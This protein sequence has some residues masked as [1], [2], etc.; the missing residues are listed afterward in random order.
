MKSYDLLKPGRLC[1]GV[2]GGHRDWLQRWTPAGQVMVPVIYY[3]FSCTIEK[4]PDNCQRH[5]IERKHGSEW[6][7]NCNNC[8]CDNGAVK[9]T[10][11]LC[12][13]QNCIS[14][15]T[16]RA[17]GCE[18]SGSRCVEMKNVSCL[19][20][21]CP[22]FGQCVQ[23]GDTQAVFKL[24]CDP[25]TNQVTDDCAKVHIVFSREKIPKVSNR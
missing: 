4:R 6:R 10:Q 20:D 8:D 15:D 9:C 5:H 12:P 23:D 13:P 11:I 2:H 19:R 24:E 3:N 22:R 14:R 17:Q 7:E 1:I 25:S 21:P 18:E 16:N